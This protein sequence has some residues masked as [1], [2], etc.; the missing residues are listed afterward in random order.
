MKNTTENGYKEK[1]Q[2]NVYGNQ[3]MVIFMKE[4]LKMEFS[5]DMENISIILQ[6]ITTLVDGIR[7]NGMEKEKS[8]ILMEKNQQMLYLQKTDF[9]LEYENN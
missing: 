3:L 4:L 1:K 9:F 2:V 8:M 6:K 7:I 5:R